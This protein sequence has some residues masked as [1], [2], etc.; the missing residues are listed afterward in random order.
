V[1]L[2]KNLS[3]GK[4]EV[5]LLKWT[6]LILIISE[7]KPFIEEYEMGTTTTSL[8][9]LYSL[10]PLTLLAITISIFLLPH[11]DLKF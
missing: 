4:L 8:Q 9:F 3:N 6:N 7:S 1:K 11:P 5:I 10:S 2:R